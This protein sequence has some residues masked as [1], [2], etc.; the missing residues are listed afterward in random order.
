V[1]TFE[2][3]TNSVDAVAVTPDGRFAL[4]GS[5]DKTLRLWELATGACVHTFEGH[6][7]QV[8]AVTVTPD[9]RFA[10]SGSSDETLRLWELDWELDVA[11]YEEATAQ[12]MKPRLFSRLGSLFTGNHK[13]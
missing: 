12:P 13:S 9:G 4:S 7:N 2:G 11:A 1:R 10:L 5:S 8:I 3:H 6:T